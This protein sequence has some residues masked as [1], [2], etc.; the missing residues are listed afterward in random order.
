MS[1][2][3][4]ESGSE[5]RPGGP[6][7]EA[8]ALAAAA[9]VT[10]GELASL[11]LA[12]ARERAG[13]WLVIALVAT[14]LLLAALLVGSLWVVSLFWDTHR[15]AAAAIV[16]LAYALTGGSLLAWLLARLRA[17]PPLLQ[18]TL[19]ELKQDCDAMRGASGPSA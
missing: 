18:A 1:A 5:P 4:D 15:S 12:E 8:V 10:R 17:A 13:R 14:M 11:E 9:L 19:A 7:R 2:I 6:V 3:A 16:A